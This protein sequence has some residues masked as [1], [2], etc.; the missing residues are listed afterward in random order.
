MTP[1]E[2]ELRAGLGGFLSRRWNAATRVEALSR[3][4]GGASRETWRCV[5]TT[6]D[7]A[8]GLILRV[9]PET[10]LIDTD[11]ATEYRAMEAAHRA[12]LPTPE[13]LFLE[14][15]PRWIGRPFSIT[16]EVTGCQA[17]PEG[18]PAA[19][20]EALGRRKWT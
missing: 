6:A 1:R 18:I 17:S 12:G 20:R 14:H 15:D 9:D 4:P 16:T 19:H 11:R 8:R 13:P 2:E 5:A 7:R 10:S 3:I